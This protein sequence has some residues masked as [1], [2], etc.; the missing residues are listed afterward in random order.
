MFGNYRRVGL[1]SAAGLVYA[2]YSSYRLNGCLVYDVPSE[3]QCGYQS[4]R[5][6]MDMTFR[7]GLM[8]ATR[9]MQNMYSLHVFTS[10]MN[11]FYT[12]NK[13]FLCKILRHL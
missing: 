6:T 10:L 8:Q 4:G 13:I 9:Y 5:R 7:A 1:L 12:V 11:A 2:K 3:L